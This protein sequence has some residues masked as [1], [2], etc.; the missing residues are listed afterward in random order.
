[1]K[2]LSDDAYDSK[3]NFIF[4]AKVGIDATIKVRKTFSGKACDCPSRKQMAL[5]YLKDPKALKRSVDRGFR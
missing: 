5:E 4:L 3:D 1:V 2:V